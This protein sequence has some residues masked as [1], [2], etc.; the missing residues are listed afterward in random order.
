[1]TTNVFA[2]PS[3][4]IGQPL[5]DYVGNRVRILTSDAVFDLNIFDVKWVDT[6]HG[7]VYTRSG[8]K[9][10]TSSDLMRKLVAYLNAKGYKDFLV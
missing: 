9:I 4:E 7:T 8:H 5:D 1:M 3:L 10:T 2:I 6:V